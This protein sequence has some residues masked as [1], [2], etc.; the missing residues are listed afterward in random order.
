MKYSLGT[1]PPDD[2]SDSNGPSPAKKKRD[3]DEENCML[4]ENLNING[5]VR[6]PH[7]VRVSF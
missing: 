7:S 2:L 5:G 6:R 1:P 4:N 3:E